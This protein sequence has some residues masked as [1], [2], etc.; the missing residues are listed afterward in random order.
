MLC[1]V[2]MIVSVILML[3]VTVRLV[4]P[5]DRGTALRMAV[6]RGN[7]QQ[8]N[9]ALSKGADVNQ[10]SPQGR[11]PL[12]LAVASGNQSVVEHLLQH[13]ADVRLQDAQGWTALMIAAQ[14]GMPGFFA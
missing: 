10:R 11:T 4:T 14:R 5:P 6:A 8:V 9:K 12:M 1:V 13:G 7:V 2:G 3:V